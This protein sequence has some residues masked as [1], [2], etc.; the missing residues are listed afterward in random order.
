MSPEVLPGGGIGRHPFFY[1]GEWDH[2]KPEQTMYIVR[3]GKIVWSYSIPS[4]EN[5]QISEFSDATL[6]SDGSIVFSRKT[7]ARMISADKKTLW[8]YVAPS[9]YEVHACQP[10]GLD[11][12]LMIQNGKQAK[13]MVVN[14]ASG[15]TE[16]E[17]N[18]ATNPVAPVHTQFRRARMTAAG[19]F[20]VP[21]KDLDKVVE[22][23]RTGK[24]IWT[25][26]VPVPWSAV[27]LKNGNTL[28]SSGSTQTIREFDAK[29]KVVWE[30][31]QKDVPGIRLFSLQ[32]ANRLANGN[33]LVTNWC[34][35]GVKDPK[36]WSQTVQVLEVTPDKKLVWALR[37]W[38]NPDLGP[39]TCAQ[40][41]DEPGMPEKFEQQR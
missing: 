13:L 10:I 9:G 27:R 6:L 33:T 21:H 14:L 17:F 26:D 2:R 3:D 31:S 29:G 30:F 5:R 8:D 34:P 11:R 1:A 35:N 16:I 18:L 4:K 36:D 37:S 25:V 39:A 20:L 23:D 15:K 12:V 24:Q 28:V 41:L 32:E 40:L 38:D 19:T 22:Y 7:G